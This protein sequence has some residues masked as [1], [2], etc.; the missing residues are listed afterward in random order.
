MNK[1]SEKK[2][3]LVTFGEI[4]MRFSPVGSGTILT[5]TAFENY[6][7]GAEL[8]VAAAAGQLGIRTAAISKIPAHDIGELVRRQ[9]LARQ[10]SDEYLVWDTEPGARLGT[11][12]YEQAYSPRKPQVVY[13]RRNSSFCGLDLDEIPEEVYD[14]CTCFHVSGINLALGEKSRALTAKLM[15]RM[16]AH[17]ALISFDVNFRGNLWTGAEAKACIEELLPMVDIFF[18]GEDT[19]RLTFQK[20][21]TVEE[22]M[23]SFA[24][25]YDIP[26]VC[27]SSR[28]AHN[29]R[30]HSF[31]AA[32]YVREDDLFLQEEPY[33]G[34]QVVDRIGS[35]DAFVGGV[36]GGLLA[37]EGDAKALALGVATGALKNTIA[38][39]MITTSKREAWLL[40][41][42]HHKQGAGCE[43]RR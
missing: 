41:E 27:S 5:A 10:V 25:D 6:I 2:Y 33:E 14:S 36:L 7:G 18:C 9:M 1:N 43:L 22:M 13:D 8:N 39:D 16:K 26:V 34:I 20:K 21:G 30:E 3:D 12:Y 32:M 31:S 28:K 40:C 23:R 29:P 35:G 19:A 37:G 4:L 42:E 11:Y 15:E 38:G 24:E 17:G